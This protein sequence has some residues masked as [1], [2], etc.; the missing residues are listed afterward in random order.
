MVDKRIIADPAHHYGSGKK[1]TRTFR[2]QR[3]TAAMNVAFVCFLAWLIV[4]LAG[5]QRAEMVDLVANPLVALPL[6]LLIVN[7]A[8]HMRIGM[9]EIIEDYLDE[10]RVNRLGRT[11]NDIFALL[12]VVLG[13]GAIIKIVFWG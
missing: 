9:L 4:R 11:A 2:W 3:I 5:A 6:G 8:L 13:L 7:V 1:A 10:D 12:V